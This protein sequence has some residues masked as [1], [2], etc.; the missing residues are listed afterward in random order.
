MVHTQRFQ[1]DG[2]RNAVRLQ[3]VEAA[4]K[5]LLELIERD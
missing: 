1:F 5:N 2:D 4:M 3:A